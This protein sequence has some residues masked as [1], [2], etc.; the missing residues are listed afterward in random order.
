[1]SE[2]LQ[3]LSRRAIRRRDELEA[4]VEGALGAFIKAG[5]ALA[6]IRDERLYLATHDRFE[7]YLR[8]RWGFASSQGYRLIDAAAVADAVSPV[9][10]IANEAQAREL[11]PVLRR[12]GPQA[13][14]EVLQS[15]DGAPLTAAR[16]RE[17]SENHAGPPAPPLRPRRT[18][19]LSWQ[20]HIKDASTR[21]LKASGRGLPD[22]WVSI[23]P[24]EDLRKWVR[25]VTERQD[26][27][28]GDE[29]GL[30][31]L[32]GTNK[33]LVEAVKLGCWEQPEVR[34]FACLLA[35]LLLADGARAP[36]LRKETR[37][38]TPEHG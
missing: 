27:P 38:D 34:D 36:R 31:D 19:G 20:R 1:M 14:R 21:R 35:R 6:E 3:R 4:L 28:T 26:L 24:A 9:G 29:G 10:E 17:A 37:E 11:V 13:V 15:L 33:A 25:A 30:L 2:D 7:D 22:L 16:L 23:N 5:K 12:G 32:P 18:P 8:E